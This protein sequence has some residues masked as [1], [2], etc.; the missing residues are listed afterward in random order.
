[1][2]KK[3]NILLIGDD[4][5][6]TLFFRSEAERAG[7]NC[8]IL[9]IEDSIDALKYLFLNYDRVGAIVIDINRPKMSGI[10]TLKRI[11]RDITLR[12]IPTA[13][14]S[15]KAQRHEIEGLYNYGANMVVTTESDI[16]LFVELIYRPKQ[17]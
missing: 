4:L 13:V 7:L 16:R 5:G 17:A 3:L 10:D 15:D 11:K 12:A 9:Q 14:L 8:E 1:M 2:Q 6:R